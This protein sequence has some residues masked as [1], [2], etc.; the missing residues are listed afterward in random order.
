MVKKMNGCWREYHN[1]YCNT[2]GKGDAADGEAGDE[3]DKA[4][5]KNR[6]DGGGYA[7]EG[8]CHGNRDYDDNDGDSGRKVLKVK[9]LT[10]LIIREKATANIQCICMPITCILLK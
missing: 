3:D 7:D 8:S 2:E 1:V 6:D 4:V 9:M 5:K 10:R